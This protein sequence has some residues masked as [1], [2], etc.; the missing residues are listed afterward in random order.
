MPASK[1]LLDG[2]IFHIITIGQNKMPPSAVQ[3][4]P[5]DRWKAIL[6]VRSLQ[7]VLPA[8]NETILKGRVR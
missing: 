6:Y 3:V 1:D 8:E 7:G 4:L 2:E 5:L